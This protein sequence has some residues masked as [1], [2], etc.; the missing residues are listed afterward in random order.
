MSSKF[1]LTCLVLCYFLT[2]S[3]DVASGQGWYGMGGWGSRCFP[4]RH[5]CLMHP[6][7]CSEFCDIIGRFC[8]GNGR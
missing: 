5:P 4:D 8:L 2:L 7:C 6:Q 3:I 1:V